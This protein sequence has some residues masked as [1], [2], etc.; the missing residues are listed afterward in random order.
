[1]GL[2][3][4]AAGEGKGKA[5]TGNG[6]RCP[7]KNPLSAGWQ[8]NSQV[9]KSLCLQENNFPGTEGGTVDEKMGEESQVM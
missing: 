7:L 4:G 6:Q 1:M 9:E 3:L 5:V 2:V 8:Q